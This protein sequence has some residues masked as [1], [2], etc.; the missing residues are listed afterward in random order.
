MKKQKNNPKYNLKI[1]TK[2]GSGSGEELTSRLFKVISKP[3]GTLL[4]KYTSFTANQITILSYFALLASA[5]FFIYSPFTTDPYKFRLIAAAFAV[6]LYLLDDVDGMI[7]R[8]KF[9]TSLKGKWMD[10]IVGFVFPSIIFFSL[11]FSLQNYYS[12]LLGALAMVCFPIQYSIIYSYKLDILP[13]MKQKEFLGMKKENKWRYIY[14]SATI[15]PILFISCLLNYP[16][17]PLVFYATF[18]NLF[19]M[20]V[21][22]LQFKQVKNIA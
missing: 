9:Q 16:W 20:L 15:Y 5:I 11:A 7:A 13:S 10:C 8:A 17:F 12:L 4:I 1:A 18:G 19:W 21:A 14:G 6:L 2:T 3:V 22:V